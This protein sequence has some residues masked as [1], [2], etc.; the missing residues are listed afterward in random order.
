MEE[1]EGDE[2]DDKNEINDE[3]KRQN[4]QMLLLLMI[5]RNV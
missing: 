1:G 3:G 5:W 2:K 4:S